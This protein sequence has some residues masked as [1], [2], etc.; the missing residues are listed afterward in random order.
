MSTQK[1][2]LAQVFAV[3]SVIA[4]AGCGAPAQPTA[5][6]AT[7]APATAL[8]ATVAPAPTAILPTSGATTAATAA[9]TAPES[10]TTALPTYT[11]L[12]IPTQIPEVNQQRWETFDASQFDESTK[13]DNP[14]F[15]LK[16]GTQ[17]VWEGFTEDAGEKIPHRVILSVTDLTKVV[18]GIRNVVVWDQDYSS[19]TLAET[20]LAFFA[21]D[22]SG[23]IWHFGQY[24]EVYEDGKLIESPAWVAGIE[25]ARP[26]I[27]IKAKP[28]LNGPSYSQGL[29]PAV[30]WTDRARVVATG[31]E[32]C[33]PAGCYKDVIV[34]EETS[35]SE[36]LEGAFQLK[37][38]AR[39]V[40]N[41][42]VDWRGADATRETLELVKINTLDAKGLAEVREKALALEKS[43]YEVSKNVYGKTKPAEAPPNP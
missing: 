40:G 1:C 16:P 37:Y 38:Y 23:I 13:I 26:G 18:E 21:Q 32:V 39:G 9:A 25:D 41:I 24:P 31:L 28:V 2:T 43:A 30:N 17:F 36:I 34:T 6:T 7:V 14:W 20:E 22:K 3:T 11:E 12:V 35:E 29:G 27:T 19:G 42:K 10:T 4:L 8:P 5:P 15:P 33:V